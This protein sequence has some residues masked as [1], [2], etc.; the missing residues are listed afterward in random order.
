M[1]P[2]A[3]HGAHLDFAIVDL[4]DLAGQ[5]VYRLPVDAV[6]RVPPQ[7]LARNLEQDALEGG[8]GGHG[9][10]L[11]SPAGAQEPSC[12]ATSAA[13]SVLSRSIP[14]PSW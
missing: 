4:G 6:G 8:E 13:K 9:G 1:L 2:A 7:R 3:D 10:L 5:P 12:A 14:S 11:R